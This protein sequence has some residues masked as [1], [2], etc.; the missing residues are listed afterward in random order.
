MTACCGDSTLHAQLAAA[1][2][3]AHPGS[4]L[5]THCLHERHSAEADLHK[6]VVRLG[7]K[8]EQLDGC[9]TC[10]LHQTINITYQEKCYVEGDA[11]SV[12]HFWAGAVATGSTM[13]IESCGPESVQGDV[14]FAEVMSLVGAQVQWQ[15]YCIN[16]TGPQ[17]DQ[18]KGIEHDCNDIPDAAMSLAVAAVFAQG[19][20]TIKHVF[21]WKVKE[22]ERMY[23]VVTEIRKLGVEVQEGRSYCTVMPP[24]T[25]KA[26]E[27]ETYHDY[28]MAMAFS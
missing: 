13:T 1:C 14:R 7:I 18:L 23:A 20:T 16:I 12:F 10:T 11:L 25:L 28:R 6:I 22:T 17:R 4:C 3:A 5:C 26:A 9:S 27:I 19:P 2:T 24:N 21:N 8:A 15:P